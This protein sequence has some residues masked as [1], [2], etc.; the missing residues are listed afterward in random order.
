[1]SLMVSCTRMCSLSCCAALALPSLP[2]RNGI[3]CGC[4]VRPVAYGLCVLAR[5]T[6]TLVLDSDI[7]K[8]P[9]EWPCDIQNDPHCSMDKYGNASD[10]NE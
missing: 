6:H 2:T 7:S 9:I 3:T 8:I 1:M 5:S 10:V 4:T